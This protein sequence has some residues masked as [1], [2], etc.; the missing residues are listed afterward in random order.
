MSNSKQKF[1]E[2]DE[3]PKTE[4]LVDYLRKAI[5]VEWNEDQRI[6]NVIYTKLSDE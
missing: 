2:E 6:I 4:F 5:T 3:L 1:I